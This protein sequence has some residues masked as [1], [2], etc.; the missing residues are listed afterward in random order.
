[1]TSP[2]GER[3]LTTAQV[4]RMLGISTRKVLERP[5]KRI[6]LGRRVVRYRLADIET[7]TDSAQRER[8]LEA[9]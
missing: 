7:F 4:A 5:L 6:E 8:H 1:M 9:Q 2:T 3:L